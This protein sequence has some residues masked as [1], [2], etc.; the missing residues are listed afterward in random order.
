Y[1]A[2]LTEKQEIEDDFLRYRREV[3]NTS[4]GSAAKEVRIL[5]SVVRNLEEELM[6]EKSKNQRA[7]NKRNQEYKTL[8][9][10]LEELRA[11]ERN[12]KARV[13]SLMNELNVLKRGNLSRRTSRSPNFPKPQRNNPPSASRRPLSVLNRSSERSRVGGAGFANRNRERSHSREGRRSSASSLVGRSRTPS[14]AGMKEPRFDPTAYI[15]E[16]KRRQQEAKLKLNRSRERSL[17]GGRRPGLL[18]SQERGRSRT[19]P[20][21]HTIGHRKGHSRGSSVGSVGSRR[22]SSGLSDVEVLSDASEGRRRTAS[23]SLAKKPLQAL[24]FDI[25]VFMG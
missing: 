23:S 11:S 4:S 18:G 21:P 14:P 22:S 6:H 25:G 15:E 16:K 12:L 10:E 1:D 2:L 24:L 7:T 19:R 13:K 20:S 9:E 17:S 8:M 5:K 3:K